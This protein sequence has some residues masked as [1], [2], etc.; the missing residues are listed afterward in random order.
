[1]MTEVAEIFGY[2]L[3]VCGH[4]AIDHYIDSS[5]FR[6]RNGRRCNCESFDLAPKKETPGGADKAQKA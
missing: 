2:Q 6:H 4:Y 5:P 1:M 3:C